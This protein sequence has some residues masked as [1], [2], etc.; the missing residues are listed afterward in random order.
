M[1]DIIFTEE[2]LLLLEDVADFSVFLKSLHEEYDIYEIDEMYNFYL[3][4]GWLS[5]CV[6]LLKF[7]NDIDNEQG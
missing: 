4:Y 3:S 5:H 6:V 7:K 1:D 2:E